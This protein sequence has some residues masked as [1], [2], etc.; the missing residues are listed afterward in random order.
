MAKDINLLPKLEVSEIKRSQ[1]QRVGSLFSYGIVGLI[2]SLL[3][4]LF[5][6][7]LFLDSSIKN[8]NISIENRKKGIEANIE[9]ELKQRALVSKVKLISPLVNANYGYSDVITNIQN[10]I[11]TSPSV[12][13]TE[14]IVQGN[15]VSFS[16]RA[17]G[18]QPIEAFLATLLNS[19]FGGKNFSKVVLKSLTR[20]ENLNEYRFSLGMIFS[21]EKQSLRSDELK[22]DQNVNTQ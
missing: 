3:V 16:A 17:P 15:D 21:P 2:V 4:G 19:S 14:V 9:K 13:P 22:K 11:Q 1:Y 12:D 8:T 7:S 20:S 10:I 6:Y 5:L 18:S